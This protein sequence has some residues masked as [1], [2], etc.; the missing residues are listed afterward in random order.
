MTAEKIF[1][2]PQMSADWI[3]NELNKKFQPDEAEKKYREVIETYEK[4]ANDAPSIGGKDNP[5][6]KNF[7][8]DWAEAI[9]DVANKNITPPEVHISGY[10]DIET[11]VPNGLLNH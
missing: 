10:V 3:R 4:F 11:F 5:M 8:G 9:E 6:S 7:Y 2:I 1:E